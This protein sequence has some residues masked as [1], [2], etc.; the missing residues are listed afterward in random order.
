MYVLTDVHI[1]LLACS[2]YR[3]G[4]LLRNAPQRTGAGGTYRRV[5]LPD[6]V[7]IYHTAGVRTR[8]VPTVTDTRH[9]TP[10]RTTARADYY[11]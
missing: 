9:H 5:Y 10:V 4:L 2:T 11:P 6:D 7:H 3:R 8:R 1:I